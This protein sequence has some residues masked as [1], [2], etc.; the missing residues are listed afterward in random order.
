MADNV[1]SVTNLSAVNPDVHFMSTAGA[2]EKINH[3]QNRGTSKF[4]YFIFNLECDAQSQSKT[5]I[6]IIFYMVFV[7]STIQI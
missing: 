1:P 6:P 5:L 4:L 2:N 7:G 3:K